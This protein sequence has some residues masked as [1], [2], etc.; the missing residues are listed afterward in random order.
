MS[1]YNRWLLRSRIVLFL[2]GT[3]FLGPTVN[4]FTFVYEQIFWLTIHLI[5]LVLFFIGFIDCLGWIGRASIKKAIC[6]ENERM[7]RG[8]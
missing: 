4:G 7:R 1:N 2:G 5:G 3:L 6:E 8:E